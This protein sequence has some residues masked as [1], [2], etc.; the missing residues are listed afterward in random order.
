MI[1][2]KIYYL[3]SF[4]VVILINVEIT[5]SNKKLIKLNIKTRKLTTEKDNPIK[6]TRKNPIWFNKKSHRNDKNIR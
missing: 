6:K 2:V 4:F 3:E 5:K 1:V